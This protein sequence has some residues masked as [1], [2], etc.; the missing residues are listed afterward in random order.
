MPSAPG[1]VRDLLRLDHEAVLADLDALRD[2]SDADA[3]LARLRLVRRKWVIHALAEETV[4][5]NALEGLQGVSSTRA[6]E[7]FVEHELVE[8][9]FDKLAAG[10]PG[11]IEWRARL[12]VAR[13]LIARHIEGE[14]EDVLARLA[15]RFDSARLA[16]LGQRFQLAREKLNLLEEAKA[17]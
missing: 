2:M 15:I 8:N 10:R 1:D 14:H 13:G 11:T 7:R 5:Y 12:N 3:T 6:A 4:V 9:L 16:D 17:A